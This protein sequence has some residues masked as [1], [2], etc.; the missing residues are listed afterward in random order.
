LRSFLQSTAI[1]SLV[2]PNSLLRTLFSNTLNLLY[3]KQIKK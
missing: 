3:K 2:A 1:S